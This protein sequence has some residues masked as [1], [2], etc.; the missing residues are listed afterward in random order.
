MIS[1]LR[2]LFKS[3]KFYSLAGSVLTAG[4]ALINFGLLARSLSKEDFGLWTFFLTIFSLFEMVRNGLVGRPLVK[5]G[6]EGD[7]DYFGS[8]VKSALIIC[9]KASLAISVLVAL[10]FFVTYLINGEMFYLHSALWF[11]VCS[12]LTIPSSFATWTNTSLIKFQ[13]VTL[14]SGGMKFFFMCGSILIYLYEW[15]LNAV[16][17]VYASSAFLTSLFTTLL[18]WNYL[19]RAMTYSAIYTRKIFDFGKYSVGT[20][21]GGSALNSSDTLLIMTFLGPEAVAIYNVPMRIIGLY[22]IPLRALVQ[23]AYP[24]LA[25]VKNRL[26]LKSF[27]REF[28]ASNGFTFLVLLPLSVL[29]FVFAEP[30][31]TL[32]GGEGYSEAAPILR[33]FSFYIAITPLDRFGGIALDVMNRPNLNF[34]K[35]MLMLL[36]NVAG[37]LLAIKLGGG[38][39]YVAV[40]SIL[41][42]SLGTFLSFYFLRDEMPFRP[43]AF[44]SAGVNETRRLIGKF[45]PF[46][47]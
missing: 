39:T 44:L 45:Y 21:L 38:I 47:Q 34:R 41:T 20:M 35:M 22:D 3:Q 29:I 37:D 19:Q 12:L 7:S 10:G 30:L 28:E 33:I 5:M 8:L 11:L 9:L 36:I 46:N 24:T 32:I 26:G 40:A 18:K 13:R 23:I 14:V 4:F 17:L 2:S 31:V 1:K 42:F 27:I 16:F 43:K 25:G 6:S 15:D